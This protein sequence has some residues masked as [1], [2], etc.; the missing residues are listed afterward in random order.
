V[1]PKREVGDARGLVSLSYELGLDAGNAVPA[2]L[3]STVSCQTFTA[4]MKTW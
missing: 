1:L 4:S 2:S 3:F